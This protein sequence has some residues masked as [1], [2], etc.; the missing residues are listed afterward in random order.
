MPT[1]QTFDETEKALGIKSEDAVVDA[2]RLPATA[3]DDER[4]RAAQTI[5]I[6]RAGIDSPDG[7]HYNDGKPLAA[8]EFHSRMVKMAQ[9]GIASLESP[10][11]QEFRALP[12]EESKYKL[13]SEKGGWWKEKVSGPAGHML[14]DHL[15][16]NAIPLDELPED[17]TPED[18]AL[19]EK[20]VQRSAN[21]K[22]YATATAVGDESATA[23]P[24]PPAPTPEEAKRIDAIRDRVQKR[25]V[26]ADYEAKLHA[27]DV[28]LRYNMVKP[29]LTP[30]ADQIVQAAAKYNSLPPEYVDAFT[31][32]PLKQQQY[33]ASLVYGFR[34]TSRDGVVM[35]AAKQMV[36]A[37]WKT[38]IE[39]VDHIAG[40]SVRHMLMGDEEYNKYA[41]T[42]AFLAN[43]EDF[44]TEDF[45]YWGNSVVSF[46][47]SLPYMYEAGV[48]AMGA[49]IGL[50][51]VAGQEY[52]QIENR[53]SAE[54][55]DVS[56]TKFRAANALA[57]LLYAKIEDIQWKTGTKVPSPLQQRQMYVKFW[58]AGYKALAVAKDAGAITVT[59]ANEESLQQGV[60]EGLVAFGLDKDIAREATAGAI[61]TWKDSLG[62]MA[63]FAAAGGA[64]KA[65][66]VNTDS[67]LTLDERVDLL[68]KRARI[69]KGEGILDPVAFD[70]YRKAT[71]DIWDMWYQAGSHD[72]AIKA[73]RDRL[74]LSEQEATGL[75]FQFRAE[76]ATIMGS[77]KLTP[78]QKQSMVGQDMDIKPVVRRLTPD[79]EIEEQP[80]GDFTITRTVRGAKHTLAVKFHDDATLD[81]ES[82]AG[83]TSAVTA[84]NANGEN[85]TVE[86]WKAMTPEDRQKAAVKHGLKADGWFTPVSAEHGV[87][88][89]SLKV[90]AGT[91]NINRAAH[92]SV[93]FHEYFHGFTRMLRDNNFLTEQDVAKLRDEFG[94]PKIAGELFDE[95]AASNA[96]R[97][98]ATAKA[99]PTSAL[100]HLWNILTSLVSALTKRRGVQKASQ[101]RLTTRES[102]FQ[103]VLAGNFTGNLVATTASTEA[104]ARVA[105]EAKATAEAQRQAQGQN[106]AQGNVEA[107]TGVEMSQTT[108]K[109]ATFTAG[110]LVHS[111]KDG[112]K[113]KPGTVQSVS[114]TPAGAFS[115][116]VKWQNGTSSDVSEADLWNAS[117]GDG[118]QLKREK[119]SKT[120]E[121]PTGQGKGVTFQPVVEK[122]AKIEK[123]KDDAVKAE[124]AG[125]KGRFTS[126][127]PDGSITVSGHLAVVDAS[128]PR[129]SDKPG[130]K[131]YLQNRLTGAVK[132]L[133]K[134]AAIGSNLITSKLG[135]MPTTDRGAPIL[136]QDLDVLAGNHR[137]WGIQYAID[138]G[139]ADNYFRW[140]RQMA[141]Q[142]G[143]EI[144]DSI[145]NPVLVR[146][147]DSTTDEARLKEIARLSNRDD[148]EDLGEA[149]RAIEDG[150]TIRKGNMLMYF[151]PGADGDLYAA[152]NRDFMARFIAANPGE[153]LEDSKGNPTTACIRRVK[154]ALFAIVMNRTADGKLVTQTLIESAGRVGMINVVN[155]VIKAAP[156]LVRLDFNKPEL[157][158]LDDLALA[159]REYM[160]VKVDFAKQ[161][162]DGKPLWESVDA[163]LAQENLFGD[164]RSKVAT[165]LIREIYY[166]QSSGGVN[167][168]LQ[169]YVKEAMQDTATGD[170]LDKQDRSK[171]G[172][173]ARAITKTA[174]WRNEA[175][176]EDTIAPATAPAKPALSAG[177]AGSVT[178]GNVTT[179][180]PAPVDPT[181]P[182]T[183]VGQG[184]KAVP[185]PTKPPEAKWKFSIPLF[186][187]GKRTMI[188]YV[189]PALKKLMGQQERDAIHTVWDGFGG[190]GGWGLTLALELFENA[191]LLSIGEFD[192]NRLAKIKFFH[193]RGDKMAEIVNDSRFQTIVKSAME[194]MKKQREIKKAQE[195]EANPT[196]SRET[197]QVSD[198]KSAGS[199]AKALE[200]A[201]DE[202]I[203][204]GMNEQ[205]IIGCVQAVADRAAN[206]AINTAD[207]KGEIY[208]EIL[209]GAVVDAANI[210]KAAQA[211]EAR[212]GKIEYRDEKDTYK[213]TIPAGPGV[214]VTADPPYN[215]TT[216]YSEDGK[217]EEVGVD[218]YRQ[219]RDL[220]K[221]ATAQ[222]N[223]V[224]Y[225]DSAW[226]IDK[227]Y[228]TE[229]VDLA[230]VKKEIG[231][232]GEQDEESK[233]KETAARKK[234]EDEQKRRDEERSILLDILNTLD[235]LDVVNGKIGNRHEVMGVQHGRATADATG[236]IA[237]GEGQ[238]QRGPVADVQQEA[239]GRVPSPGPIRDLSGQT[240]PGVAEGATGQAP[241]VR[242][243]DDQVGEGTRLS[244]SASGKYK[245]LTTAQDEKDI[246]RDDLKQF[247]GR[248]WFWMPDG[249]LVDVT[250]EDDALGHIGAI[251]NAP[252]P[253]V[254]GLSEKQA[255]KLMEGVFDG[256]PSESV[257]LPVLAFGSVRVSDMQD[258]QGPRRISINLDA[259]RT[260]LTTVQTGLSNHKIPSD[261]RAQYIIEAEGVF[262]TTTL[263]NLTAAN[264]WRDLE[265]NSDAAVPQRYSVSAR[266]GSF[267]F[268]DTTQPEAF[269]KTPE[270]LAKQPSVSAHLKEVFG[271]KQA[272]AEHARDFHARSS[273]MTPGVFYRWSPVT[274]PGYTAGQNGKGAGDGLYLGRDPKALEA[275][276]GEVLGEGEGE[277]VAYRIADGS[278][279]IKWLDL[280]DDTVGKKVEAEAVKKYH[281]PTPGA[282]PLEERDAKGNAL[283]Q[284]ALAQGY[285][286]VRYYDPEA[287]G[288]EFVLYRPEMLVDV[289]TG[290]SRYSLSATDTAYLAAVKRDD[291]AE[292][293]RIVDEEAKKAGYTV[294]AWH[295]TPDKT[296][297]VFDI[298]HLGEGT[299]NNGLNG[300]GFYFTENRNE[301]EDYNRDKQGRLGRGRLIDAYLKLNN[302]LVTEDFTRH[303]MKMDPETTAEEY[304]VAAKVNFDAVMSVISEYPLWSP[305][306]KKAA[307]AKL[308]EL[309]KNHTDGSLLESFMEAYEAA[310]RRRIMLDDAPIELSKMTRQAGYDGITA[311]YKGTATEIVVFTP[312]QI[313]SASPITMDDD[314]HIVPPSARFQKENPDIRFSVSAG[315]A[316]QADNA[317]VTP[318]D[319]R[320]MVSAYHGTPHTFE[321]E[322]DAPFGKVKKEKVGT[323]EGAAAYGWGVLYT[324]QAKEVAES[325]R[326]AF[327]RS[328]V[329]R[330]DGVEP[331]YGS[332]P[333]RAG[334]AVVNAGGDWRKA[335]QTLRREAK[336]TT[337]YNP[338]VPIQMDIA[339]DWLEENHQRVTMPKANL[340]HV[341]LDLDPEDCL[342]W[343]KPLSEQSERVKKALA[344]TDVMKYM[345]PE[346]GVA[347]GTG[348]DLYSVLSNILG[349]A[350]AFDPKKW[351][352]DDKPNQQAASE[353]LASLGIK[354]IRYAD[355]GSRNWMVQ[356]SPLGGQSGKWYAKMAGVAGENEPMVGP[357][358][359]QAEARRAADERSTFNFVVFNE[360]DIRVVGRNGET[361]KPSDATQGQPRASVS[362]TR[363]RMGGEAYLVA[364]AAAEILAGKTPD[365][366]SY[367][368][369]ADVMKA[370][371]TADEIITRA[372][373]Y[374]ESKVAKAAQ[375]ALDSPDPIDGVF[376]IARQVEAD[377]L[378]KT[379]RS[380]VRKGAK[381]HAELSEAGNKALDAGRKA[382]IAAVRGED[383]Q[384]LVVDTGID[385]TA[386]VADA[387][388]DTFAETPGSGDAP[389]ADTEINVNT[390]E[391]TV[392][393]EQL[394][395]RDQRCRNLIQMAKDWWAQERARREKAAQ[396]RAAARAAAGEQT[397]EEDDAEQSEDQMILAIP[398]AL[399][400]AAKVDL[401]NARELAHLIRLWIADNM[402]RQSKGRLTPATLWSDPESVEKYRKTVRQQLTQMADALVDSID[403]AQPTIKR[404]IGDITG[405]MTPDQ[406]E[407]MSAAVLKTINSNHIRQTRNQQIKEIDKEVAKLVKDG[408]SFDATK[409]DIKRK[410]TAEVEQIAR[411]LPRI[412]RYTD[413]KVAAE[414]ER[415]TA[416]MEARVQAVS[417]S[418]APDQ[419]VALDVQWHVA[420]LELQ[421][422]NRY[423]GLKY[424]MPAEI[425]QAKR[426]I[427]EDWLGPERERMIAK[428]TATIEQDNPH[429]AALEQAISRD[430]KEH[431][432]PAKEG[433]LGA[434]ADSLIATI[435]QRMQ[436][437]V[438]FSKGDARSEADATIEHLML[439]M[440]EGSQS[441]VATLDR[442]REQM[443]QVIEQA[444]DGDARGYLKHLEDTIPA[445]VAQAISRQ[446][447]HTGMT[448]GQAVQLYASLTQASYADN[449]VRHGRQGQAAMLEGILTAQ[450]IALVLGLRRMYQERRAE[451]SAIVEAVTGVPIWSPDPNYMP[452]RIFRDQR[453][454]LKTEG[455]AW[456]ALANQLAPRVAHRLDFDESADVL[457]MVKRGQETAARAIAF[458]ERGI[459]VRNILTNSK[460]KAAILRY[461]GPEA[462]SRLMDHVN[463]HLMGV[464][465][466]AGGGTSRLVRAVGRMTSYAAISWNA[467]S[468]IKQIGSIPTWGLVLNGG[469]I[470][471]FRALASFDM[472]S[473]RELADSDGF[474]ARY[475]AGMVV[476]IQEAMAAG[477]GRGNLLARL[478]QAGFQP[479]QAADKLASM[480]IGTG[481][482]K[483]KR[484]ALIDQGMDPA[485][486]MRN[487]K[488]LTFNLI[489]ECQQSARPENQPE[490]LRRYGPVARMF[491]QF[492]SAPALQ[493]SHEVQAIRDVTAGV[494]GAKGKLARAII[495]NHMLVPAIMQGLTSGFA[496]MLGDEPDD[497]FWDKLLIAML[498][499][500]ASRIL[501]LGAMSESA[502][503]ALIHGR[504][505]YF[506]QRL[507]PAEN[508][509]RWSEIGALTAHHLA[510]A[511]WEAIQK[512]L[513]DMIQATGAPQRAVIKWWKNR[514]D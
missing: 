271:S 64:G 230:P 233:K 209:A 7:S 435:R 486:A 227:P 395:D 54:G 247:F 16:G 214:F 108:E 259:N 377:D 33:V 366:A 93:L 443:D 306:Q 477:E 290:K 472:Q 491:V 381:L 149:E 460:V 406:I 258:K 174:N 350:P 220:V 88:E 385:L 322:P 75:A 481:V 36:K 222:G 309:E 102:M 185:T 119:A 427:I 66:R 204:A 420:N 286:G 396:D 403:R 1:L 339:A 405:T 131:S 446:G 189:V 86:E 53:V 344:G 17:L 256:D 482:Y 351:T 138:N 49:P 440:G 345:T 275:M 416:L 26:I 62:S 301:A 421:M 316:I 155:G 168:L 70:D 248:G 121:T 411:K 289:K 514:Q 483:A 27:K 454:G 364:A 40:D 379:A 336:N 4:R 272:A 81:L 439:L 354:G 504:R 114:Q 450:D 438:R 263:A 91:I 80:N 15:L 52:R 341:E 236:R 123:G 182:W 494:D 24:P 118:S 433:P 103:Q 387:N 342:D 191:K 58:K 417:D 399:L 96:F 21:L 426:E 135:Q 156:D 221:K 172:N 65:I 232:F 29:E 151:A 318:P 216:G 186:Q 187:G 173:L 410:V 55:G 109:T 183:G 297:T 423:G 169:E 320:Y 389:A 325:Y 288:E 253:R 462:L 77:D 361:L 513:L 113:G 153:A 262:V 492:A 279:P 231:L 188:D 90:L 198:T 140:V 500:P 449:V 497:E 510:T 39:G 166:R 412:I 327:Q 281:K 85:M 340:Y 335:V 319:T 252:N 165:E 394:A 452:V 242:S 321:P 243:G 499:G 163:W 226:W 294:K 273:R 212:N 458:G 133:K 308:A 502:I 184:D 413:K 267:N 32:L 245:G 409:A 295:G 200:T 512:D 302:P 238:S 193:Q 498:I 401:G 375:A 312:T 201:L 490:I 459:H 79:A 407:G 48:T 317:T 250:S 136:T 217:P 348:A 356:R 414:V 453:S 94:A 41:Q 488:T 255:Q 13:A 154:L 126:T 110:E 469:D 283:R 287:T 282:S 84:M 404:M 484:D 473:M 478:Y 326:D 37:A 19:L 432:R 434:F 476:E 89:G 20:D 430:P 112:K 146:V 144:P 445:D 244:V 464:D 323:G 425:E 249:T 150:E 292:A 157:S 139:L 369:L 199:L 380:G 148:K 134:V 74:G 46:A 507:I 147:I 10:E 195:A 22:A 466:R 367:Q 239:D 276:Y 225:T 9:N 194:K 127:T 104:A 160:Q 398:Q 44:K 310:T 192:A 5:S 47:A 334:E 60:E 251:L 493:L 42:R 51:L 384:A 442:Y 202:A 76:L 451:L 170:L 455:R 171:E 190:S 470:N 467:L 444:S 181:K 373:T 397:E 45:G 447:Y 296:F 260:S 456:H 284:Y 365:A 8:S 141:A 143:I 465:E 34:H 130:Y 362:A 95:E 422:I 224:L 505:D 269:E 298:K 277:L 509:V 63:M 56:D 211:F 266:Q 402:L 178:P 480:W 117:T 270:Q 67:K 428:I 431:G 78:T 475:G 12:D 436:N 68:Y 177:S 358:D 285:D 25:R 23:I 2:M 100:G 218:I 378:R 234:L 50:L 120:A 303:E 330:V 291:M 228:T 35:S 457:A 471:I 14:S 72:N 99:K 353:Y 371:K 158:I 203:K 145:K 474:K 424:R 300:A 69:Q 61:Q 213:A 311:N 257:L 390:A 347:Y 59:E 293:Q 461:H 129:T 161:R 6:N 207:S 240:L 468:A 208:D 137:M 485:T 162:E 415:I 419:D 346:K 71:Q 437:L 268:G 142:E 237:D 408:K 363:P 501:F 280:T 307:R 87:T 495:I 278:R 98:Y 382:L 324:A 246:K 215:R 30:E 125:E 374:A 383:L 329:A 241:T 487:A 355:Q 73:F 196:F 349:A 370:G 503:R 388:P 223:V 210:R 418:S 332:P 313:K 343:D 429:I 122:V 352:K 18:R 107:R 261:S 508:I 82:D 152:S 128:T 92:P 197:V 206:G 315:P 391:M 159:V 274:I 328:T 299:E 265:K 83:A 116:R 106:A 175:V 305:N 167:A 441:Y 376:M 372:K 392:T 219:T 229:D 331:E 176:E 38:P 333:W 43:M 386:T 101:D 264:S 304:D 11:S 3:T 28:V 506:G 448:Y 180:A 57:S 337:L 179:P 105:R 393:P 511:D 463:D 359:T 357:F 254:F 205:D 314:G 31:A 97:D 489:E 124:I 115:Y 496:R 164:P 479:I 235:H 360:Q 338:G 111:Q 400:D 132:S 368:R